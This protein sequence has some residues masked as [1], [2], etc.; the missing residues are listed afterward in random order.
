MNDVAA[1]V[2]GAVS[3]ALIVGLG[4]FVYPWLLTQ[5]FGTWI[6]A[7]MTALLA[8]LFIVFQGSDSGTVSRIGAAAW[9]LGP[10]LAGVIVY[11]I[12][13]KP[14]PAAIDTQR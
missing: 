6:V 11:R 12:Q 3:I 8:A 14:K 5:R 2:A 1:P 13:N 9:S 7:L 4:I 10:V